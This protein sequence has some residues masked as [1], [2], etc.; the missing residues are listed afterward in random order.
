MAFF[1]EDDKQLSS[2][3]IQGKMLISLTTTPARINKL[4]PVLCALKKALRSKRDNIVIHIPA[5]FKRTG[6]PYIIPHFLQKDPD[7]IINHLDVDYGPATK[8]VGCLNLKTDH[9]VVIVVDDDAIYPRKIIHELYKAQIREPAFVHTRAMGV[10]DLQTG[11][12]Q[13][14]VSLTSEY[15]DPVSCEYF[16]ASLGM[17]FHSNFLK[18]K[19]IDTFVTCCT[20]LYPPSFFGDDLVISNYF[21]SKNIPIVAVYVGETKSKTLGVEFTVAS[22]TADALEKGAD[23]QCPVAKTLY[24]DIMHN[25]KKHNCW[26]ITDE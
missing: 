26:F 13:E 25:L 8:F 2:H 6:E 20:K 10:M 7:I 4:E 22:A 5:V 3:F 1:S 17:S 14:G 21:A 12:T 23:G 16:I 9:K 11:L 18:D 15:E 19:D 24:A